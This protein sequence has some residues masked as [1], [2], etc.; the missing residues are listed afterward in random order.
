MDQAPRKRIFISYA[1]TD[2]AE[3]AQAL[4]RDLAPAG[5]DVWLDTTALKGGS[6]WS[7]D[8]ERVLDG[9]EIVLALLTR[10][11]F[12]SEICR[13]EQLRAL[14]K[15]KCLIP[16]LAQI[17]A[18]RPL[19]LESRQYRDLSDPSTYQQELTALLQ[20]IH[21]SA[22][23]VLVE[24]YRH[25]YSTVP[26][27]PVNYVERRLELD[28]LRTAVLGD[29]ASR[30]IA[31]IA[32]KGMGGIGK[33]ILAQALCHDELTRAA[34]PDGVIWLPVGQNPRDVLTLMREAAK[35]VGDDPRSY[36]TLQAATNELRNH[37]RDKAVLLVLDDV[38]D[39]RDAAP[40]L[41][42]AP[43]SRTLL[44][45]RDGRVATAL[46]AAQKSLSVLSEE[47]ALEL[48]SVWS[49]C[50][51]N[52]LPPE[53]LSIVRECGC[54][55]LALAMVGAL[56][57]GKPHRWPNLLHKLEHADLEGIRQRFPQ[58]PHTDLPRAIEVSIDALAPA[59]RERYLDFAIFPEDTPIPE[60]ALAT[61][62]RLDP[63]EVQDIADELVDLSLATRNQDGSLRVHDLLVDYLRRRA[64]DEGA[65]QRHQRL[66]AAYA[67][68]SGGTWAHG[69]VDGYYFENL[70]YHLRQAGRVH[71]A[72]WLL[73]DFSWIEAKLKAC[74]VAPLLADYNASTSEDADITLLHETLRLSAYVLVSDPSQLAGQLLGR[75]PEDHS[76]AIT[77]VRQEALARPGQPWLLPVNALLTQPGGALLL[78]L[79]GHHGP[80]RTVALSST[81][82]R[83]VSGSDDH[84]VKIWD[85]RRGRLEHSC[86]GHSDWV[87][88]VAM[89][90]GT[91]KFV[92]AGD[93]HRL[94]V[95][96]LATGRE[97]A[98]FE[99]N[100]ATIRAL[101]GLPG[102]RVAAIA[103]DRRIRVWNLITGAIETTL[104]VHAG[105]VNCLAAD[106]YGAWIVTGGDDRMLRVWFLDSRR[107]QVLPG[108]TG[109]VTG[110]AVS[111]DG[112]RIVSIAADGTVRLWAMQ[113]AQA[114]PLRTIAEGAFGARCLAV[115]P[116]GTEIAAALEDTLLRI[117][118]IDGAREGVLEGHSELVNSLAV[119]S[120]GRHV[121][122]ASNDATLKMWDLRR[123]TVGAAIRRE[124]G[125]AVLNLATICKDWM[126][127]SSSYDRTLRIWDL[128][129]GDLVRTMTD[130]THWIFAVTPDGTM[131]VTSGSSG[132]CHVYDMPPGRHL[133]DF[134]GHT[135]RIRA[136]AIAPDARRIVSAGDDAIRIWDAHTQ[137]QLVRIH[138]PT[139]Q[140]TRTVAITPDSGRAVT[141]GEGG[142][143][144]VWDM[145]NGKELMSL[146]GHSARI[147]SVA[148]TADG[149]FVVSAADDNEVRV[150]SL[151]RG[152][153]VNV[154]QGHTAKVNA[155][156]LAAWGPYAVSASDDCD[157][158]LWNLETGACA[159]RFTTEMPLL[160]CAAGVRRPLILAG[161]R[162]GSIYSFQVRNAI[163]L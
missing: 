73:L 95:W 118:Q 120:D 126:A 85:L 34:F 86:A 161:D 154:L 39:A 6:S 5:Y 110:V 116:S 104:R 71:E 135:D 58:Y 53:A 124:H 77:R 24:Q 28:A 79:T 141:G 13:A 7:A 131:L 106:P 98:S 114:S 17:N 123:S 112:S 60:A 12:T 52:S 63:F 20:D 38:W 67:E 49:D 105:D 142:R 76:D 36:D 48:I 14:R 99:S 44:T 94:K 11:S 41:I 121:V 72:E 107:E 81:G 90:P 87:R 132:A 133:L 21:N 69:P 42:D 31:L 1:H 149:R 115:S 163:R 8:I 32:L 50:P 56:L 101:A 35:A 2:A 65:I 113:N 111:Q 96:D 62:W 148:I 29:Q 22:G 19:Y 80:V 3:L 117:W 4:H 109:R 146:W 27:L 23:A 54:L 26:P 84:T 119:S 45:T 155:V 70:S 9:T 140:S 59:V 43:R 30:R 33:T 82:W 162:F 75:L 74:G 18:D 153:C 136:L 25:T 88:A 127:L 150:W 144:T 147:N 93:D 83:A 57:R 102:E 97:Q 47:Q 55:P 129:T 103:N 143:I 125:G 10:A 51:V 40:F 64:G 61:L 157:V 130:H 138:T 137:E 160:S 158:R 152:E 134:H 159:A 16:V 92:S 66:L 46:G 145:Q 139:R 78:T 128:V 100:V 68:K 108:H 151:D 156:S 37:L 89:L 122:S 15:G 91:Q